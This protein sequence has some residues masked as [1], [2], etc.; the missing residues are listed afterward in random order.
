MRPSQSVITFKHV[1][2]SAININRT[3]LVEDI[4]RCSVQDN[5]LEPSAVTVT[6]TESTFALDF[7]P[8]VGILEAMKWLESTEKTIGIDPL[9]HVDI[10]FTPTLK[11][12]ADS[13]IAISALNEEWSAIQIDKDLTEVADL[14]KLVFFCLN[15]G[16]EK[17]FTTLRSV[18]DCTP[19]TL[20]LNFVDNLTTSTGIIYFVQ[21]AGSK[22]GKVIASH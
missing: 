5:I 10:K 6:R 11:V 21:T 18:V 13:A 16:E 4:I 20:Y 12:V 7:I 15:S 2:T 19:D 17:R 22:G 9:I 8:T 3:E 1:T 14:S